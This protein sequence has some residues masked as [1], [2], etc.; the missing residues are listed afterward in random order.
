MSFGHTERIKCEDDVVTICHK[1][2]E[3]NPG[4]LNVMM[5]MLSGTAKIDPDAALG[6]FAHLLNLDTF[7]IYGS[8]IWILY[9]DICCENIVH[10]IT[11]LRAVQLGFNGGESG[12]RGLFLRSC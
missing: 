5:Q 11:V 4:A 8:K 10:T 2:S 1:L 12:Y 9:K 6:P 7:G 3:G